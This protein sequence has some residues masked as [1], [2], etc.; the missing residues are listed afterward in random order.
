MLTEAVCEKC[1]GTGWIIIERAGVS[2]AEACACRAQG[3]A[4]RLQDRS[5]I[6]PLYRGDSFD[7]FVVPGPENPIA[8]REL[9][10]VYFNVK[11]FAREFPQPACPGL[12][13]IGEPGCGKTHLAVAAAHEIMKKGFQVWFCTFQHLLNRIKAGYD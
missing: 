7:N 10:T 5:E 9:S 3:R 8:R 6:P 11:A 2:G 13:L 12:L 4:E 1:G